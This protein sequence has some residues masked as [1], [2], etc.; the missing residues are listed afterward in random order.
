LHFEQS[1]NQNIIHQVNRVK[2]A[3]QNK[4]AGVIVDIVPSYASILVQFDIMK[5][6]G[7]HLVAEIEKCC[8]SIVENISEGLSNS[9]TEKVIEIPIYYGLDVGFDLPVIAESSGL[10][11]DEV[12]SI[13]SG[14]L[15]TV[16]AVGF[17]PGF[18]YMGSVDSRIAV[19]R[20]VNPRKSIPRNSLAIANQQTAIYPSES[21]GGWQVVGRT[22][23]GMVDYGCNQPSILSVG[24]TIRFTP[25]SQADFIE[26]GGQL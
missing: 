24:D 18:A 16:Y 6:S 10:N 21:P 1:I 19:P 14:R 3:L 12:V 11:I 26:M 17:A 2:S 15:Y 20:K 5:I 4:F 8:E 22:P 9:Q 25:I 13:H 23:L 7:S